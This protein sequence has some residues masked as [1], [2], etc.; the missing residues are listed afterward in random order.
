MLPRSIHHG[1]LQHHHMRQGSLPLPYKKATKSRRA[2]AS[3]IILG[4]TLL[5]LSAWL[6]AYAIGHIV[7]AIG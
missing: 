7:T 5:M 6:A 2:R 4:M 3:D 1:T